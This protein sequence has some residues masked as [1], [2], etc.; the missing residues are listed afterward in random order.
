MVACRRMRPLLALTCLAACGGSGTSLF[1]DGGG[2]DAHVPTNTGYF[3]ASSYSGISGTTPIQGGS[4]SATFVAS[5][6]TVCSSQQ[7]AE[8]SVYTCPTTTPPTPVYA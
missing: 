6:G 2:P 3:Q 5:G 4:V 7:V 1:G 8:C